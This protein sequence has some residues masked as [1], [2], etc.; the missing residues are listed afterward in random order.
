[1]YDCGYEHICGFDLQRL[2]YESFNLRYFE[3]LFEIDFN[4][5]IRVDDGG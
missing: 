5:M 4:L 2:V 3:G 1:M